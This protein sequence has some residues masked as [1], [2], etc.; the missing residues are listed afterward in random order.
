[1]IATKLEQVIYEINSPSILAK[2]KISVDKYKFELRGKKNNWDVNL[3]FPPN[4]PYC[5]PLAQLLNIEFIGTIP[6]VSRNGEICVEEGDSVLIDYERPTDI[7]T[8]FLEDV[9]KLLER[10]RLKIYQ[11][12]LLD[13]YEGYFSLKQKVNSFYYAQDNVEYVSLK[14]MYRENNRQQKFPIPILLYDRNNILPKKFSNIGD[15]NDLQVTNVIHF[16]LSEAMLPPSSGE[17]ITAVYISTIQS[18][19]SEKQK[20]KLSKLLEKEKAKNQFFI[21]LSMPRTSGERSQLLLQFTASHSF[22]HPLATLQ[23]EWK[24]M[25]FSINRHNKEYLLE[26]GGG[27]NS[28]NNKKVVVIGC[29]SVGSEIVTM[30]AKSGVGEF[31]LVD[32]DIFEADNI[33]RHRLG[34][35]FLNFVPDSKTSV[36]DGR[37]KV[38]ALAAMLSGELPFVKFHPK[39]VKFEEAIADKNLLNSDIIIIAVGSP[40]TNLLINRKL[41]VLGLNKVVFCWNEASGYG[42]HSLALDLTE[43]CLECIYTSEYGFVMENDISLVKEGQNIS[44]N[45]TGCAGVFTPFSYLDSTQTAVI[46]VKQSIDLLLNNRHSKALSWKGDNNSTLEVTARYENMS[47]KEEVSL[48]RKGKCRVC[49][50]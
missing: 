29:G 47:L 12:E 40:T 39:R 3:W 36:V 50:A 19:I 18:M 14:I 48:I 20:L 31:T 6:H 33:H 45:L 17:E 49:N 2:V 1:M 24:I 23:H 16:P 26:R 34:G 44:K 13:E 46:A 22:P 4:F 32:D 38:K 9:I 7:I 43:S 28:L 15:T 42:G 30:L 11:D 8:T 35:C 27:I 21:L 37:Y 5:L 25:P 10:A 41:K